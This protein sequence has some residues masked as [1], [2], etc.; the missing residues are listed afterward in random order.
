MLGAFVSGGMGWADFATLLLTLLVLSLVLLLPFQYPRRKLAE[1]LSRLE[2]LVRFWIDARG[3]S[4]TIKKQLASIVK[5]LDF[6]EGTLH[7]IISRLGRIE[8]ALSQAIKSSSPLKLKNTGQEASKDAGIPDIAK[9]YLGALEDIDKKKMTEYVIQQK[10]F[11]FCN[12]KLWSHLD[13]TEKAH[14]DKVAFKRGW[15]RS[16]MLQIAGIELRDAVFKKHNI[17]IETLQD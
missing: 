16:V 17:N 12:D 13:D 4:R 9:K 5:R 3:A 1:A 14:I 8:G 7:P 10:C 2:K 15:N 11:D 6:I